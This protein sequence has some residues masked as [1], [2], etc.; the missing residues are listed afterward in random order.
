MDVCFLFFIFCCLPVGLFNGNKTSAYYMHLFF[1]KQKTA[2]EM[3]I[4]D[5][6]PTCALPICSNALSIASAWLAALHRS[7]FACSDSTALPVSKFTFVVPLTL[8]WSISPTRPRSA[9]V[10]AVCWAKRSEEHTSELQS[11]MR[12]SYAV[13]CLN[14]KMHTILSGSHHYSLTLRYYT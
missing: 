10:A 14:K 12:I 2:Y 1:F 11:L 7:A 4:S 6:V 9:S 13:F 3:R 8:Y 5:W